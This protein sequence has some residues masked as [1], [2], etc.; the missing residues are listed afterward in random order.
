MNDGTLTEAEREV[1]QQIADLFQTTIDVVGSRGAARGRNIETDLP[2]GKG[3]GTRSDIDV[4]IDGQQEIDLRGA[5]SD[6]LYNAVAGIS[7]GPRLLG[8]SRP[9][10]IEIKPKKRP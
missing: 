5:L 9:P 8:G 1:L 6:A 10:L 7:V 2:F 3:S 4:Q